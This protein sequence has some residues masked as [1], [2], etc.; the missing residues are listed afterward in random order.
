MPWIS[1]YE[2][3]NVDVGLA[4]GLKGKGPDRQGHV[5]NSGQYGGYDADQNRS[6]EIRR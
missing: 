3:R 1:A 4:C 2:D 6:R 5:G